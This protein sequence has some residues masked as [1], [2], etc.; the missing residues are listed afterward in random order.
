MKHLMGFNYSWNKEIIAQFY[1]T[2]YFGYYQ[3]ET[4][5]FWMMEE[6]KYHITFLAFVSLFRLGNDD[7]NFPKLHDEGVLEHK[8]MHFVPSEL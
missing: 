4:P 1:A 8:E 3:N 2:M 5:M 7:I 6:E